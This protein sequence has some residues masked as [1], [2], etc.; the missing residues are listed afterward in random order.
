MINFLLGLPGGGKSYEA[1]VFH[2]LE[3][4][5]RGR[6]VITNLPV[7][8]EAYVAIVPEARDLLEVRRRPLPIRGT[9]DPAREDSAY[10]LDPEGRVIAPPQGAR[11]FGGLWD[12]FDTWRHPET[13]QGALFVIDECH[14]AL[15]KMKT[16]QEVEE[17]YSLHR[18]FNCDVLL[19]T[20]SYGKISQSIR[21]LVQVVYRVRKNIEL[22]TPK[23]YTRKVQLGLRGEV[24]NTSI[25][26]Y[27]P[28]YFC[29]YRSH[30]QGGAAAEANASDVRPLWKHWSFIGAAFCAVLLVVILATGKVKAPWMVQTAPAT[31]ITHQP[32]PVIHAAA[33]LPD[34]T[35][36]VASAPSA[37]IP[38]PAADPFSGRGLHLV[39]YMKG[40][41][42]EVWTFVI[43]QNGQGLITITDAELVAAGYTWKGHS[44]CSGVL[45]YQGGTRNV[46]CDSPQ[47]GVF[48]ST[49]APQPKAS[50]PGSV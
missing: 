3:A 1:N 16:S 41:A 40:R 32:S 44:H 33:P 10:L 37:P 12:Y 31:S 24:V 5:K 19:I 42:R 11:V 46:I 17:W 35:S 38:A 13:G 22:G 8:V 21:D 39:G 18:H 14:L 28:E 26:E 20:Q 50:G 45:T 49:P 34:S 6:K 30:T 9:W 36:A 23:N 29:L 25:R 48:S 15:P 7:N 2:V 27:K 4:L 47:V 43:S